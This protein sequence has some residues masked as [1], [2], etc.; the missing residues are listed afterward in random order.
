MN[1]NPHSYSEY[2]KF[3]YSV[4]LD[5]EIKQNY[6]FQKNVAK[7]QD[8]HKN[9]KKITATS[10]IN[11]TKRLFRVSVPNKVTKNLFFKNSS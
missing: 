11:Y 1:L 8:R 5:Q 2:T 9:F 4:Q 10:Q 3:A 6:F 7:D